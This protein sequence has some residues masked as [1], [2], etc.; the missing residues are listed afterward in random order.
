MSGGDALPKGRV[1]FS[2][3]HIQF[4]DSKLPIIGKDCDAGKN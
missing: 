1:E 2:G 4:G 3:R